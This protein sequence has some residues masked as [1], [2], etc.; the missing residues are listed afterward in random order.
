M[1]SYDKYDIAKI[2]KLVSPLLTDATTWPLLQRSFNL[3]S[4]SVTQ[5]SSQGFKLLFRNHKPE[6]HRQEVNSSRSRLSVYVSLSEV[7]KV[8]RF[9]W[10]RSWWVFQGSKEGRWKI[11]FI[12]VRVGESELGCVRVCVNTFYFA[13]GCIIQVGLP[14][15]SHLNFRVWRKSV[16]A[17]EEPV[18]GF[19][20]GI[21]RLSSS[22]GSGLFLG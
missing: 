21:S 12:R 14:W 15:R 16:G 6:F 18:W 19:L 17:A 2:W 11:F 20:V 7:L 10:K 1:V 13:G 5:T 3:L 9:F 8:A 4:S 22:V